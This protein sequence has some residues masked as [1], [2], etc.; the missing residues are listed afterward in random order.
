M[1][2]YELY[3]SINTTAMRWLAYHYDLSKKDILFYNYND[4]TAFNWLL[5]IT[6][7]FCR[8]YGKTFCVVC[9]TW[10]YLYFRYICR[11]KK[12]RRFTGQIDFFKIDVQ[13]FIQELLKSFDTSID[14]IYNIYNTYYRRKLW[15]R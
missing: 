15:L 1:E 6:D 7:I 8:T 12:I 2:K 11:F 14:T 3:D 10:K 9:P 5:K 13:I 4:K